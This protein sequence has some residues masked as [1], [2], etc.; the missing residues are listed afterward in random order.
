MPAWP[1][2]RNPPRAR[3]PL[4]HTF[5]AKQTKNRVPELPE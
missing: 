5:W 3:Q 2:W 4:L 1:I